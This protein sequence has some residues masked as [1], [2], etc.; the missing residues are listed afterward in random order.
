MP[1][2]SR[3]E[4]KAAFK[5]V[6][7]PNPPSKDAKASKVAID[8]AIDK[9]DPDGTLDGL[10]KQLVD[11]KEQ[12]YLVKLVA[13]KYAKHYEDGSDKRPSWT[14]KFPADIVN[15]AL[16]IVVPDGFDKPL[17][18]KTL[19]RAVGGNAVELRDRK[20]VV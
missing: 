2:K 11:S 3:D 16:A 14:T 18:Q 4:F 6:K 19:D 5:T 13:Y 10:I 9:G 12:D 20:S 7:K 8:K 17:T 1:K 15:A